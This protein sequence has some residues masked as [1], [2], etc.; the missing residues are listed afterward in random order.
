MTLPLAQGVFPFAVHLPEFVGCRSLEP[1]QRRTVHLLPDQPAPLQ[2]AM[3]RSH[4]QPTPFLPSQNHLHFLRSPSRLLA[5][6]PHALLFPRCCLRRAT[7]RTPASLG[8][9]GQTVRL[10]V[11]APP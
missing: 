8:Q 4:R 1:R 6:S 7:M 5:Q 9:R 3:N 10:L 11:T 2:N